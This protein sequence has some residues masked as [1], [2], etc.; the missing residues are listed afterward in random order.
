MADVYLAEKA[1]AR[2]VFRKVALKRIHPHL[3]S[4]PKFV[5]LF[6][7]EAS[8][9]LDLKHPNCVTVL[10]F[11]EIEGGLL[12]ALDYIDGVALEEVKKGWT[13]GA[14]AQVLLGVLDGLAAAHRHS[15]GAIVHRD[16][17]PTNI[18]IDRDGHVKLMDFGVAR[19]MDDLSVTEPR[20]VRRYA[21]PEAL[22]GQAVGPPADLYSLARTCLDVWGVDAPLPFTDEA[23]R[24]EWL[25]CRKVDWKAVLKPISTWLYEN[26]EARPGDAQ[27][28][29]NECENDL[30]VD[31]VAGRREL[32]TIIE[33]NSGGECSDAVPGPRRTRVLEPVTSKSMEKKLDEHRRWSGV[34]VAVSILVILGALIAT[35]MS[36]L[37]QSTSHPANVKS[38][39]PPVLDALLRIDSKPDA[40]V[41]LDGTPVGETPIVIKASPGR[42]DVELVSGE[43]KGIYRKTVYLQPGPQRRNI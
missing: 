24:V 36:V 30:S 3:A 15:K 10:G 18:L 22:V 28:A 9:A 12:L 26:P 21:A 41:R 38:A 43:G 17:S 39:Y 23:E 8:I 5:D 31:L 37:N 40:S 1:E 27:A 20:G 29:L 32:Q 6:I 2:G 4:D 7:R 35:T 34:W 42:H 33:Q 16:V 14:A 13:P 19:A 11:E 25:E